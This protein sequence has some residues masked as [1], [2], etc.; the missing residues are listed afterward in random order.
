MSN[1]LATNESDS[2]IIRY[3]TFVIFCIAATS[4][5][6]IFVA[7]KPMIEDIT[8]ETPVIVNIMF[9]PTLIIGFLYGLKI[10]ERVMQPSE[11]RTPFKR[12]IVKLF[13]FFF[14]IGGLFSSV[15]FALHGGSMMPEGFVFDV[16]VI[17]S[18]GFLT[19]K[20]RTKDMI[21]SG[22]SNIYPREVEEV[23]L[24]HDAVLEASVVGRIHP[25]WGEEVV[26]FVVLKPDVKAS[27][28]DLDKF[29]LDN[30]AR[31]KRPKNY[32]FLKSLPKNNYGKILKT[33]LREQLESDSSESPA[34]N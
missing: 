3:S 30:I 18:D 29:C 23:L 4:A 6:I 5:L 8:A 13:L 32:R 22:G 16:G 17:D 34:V 14:V 15:N 24:R 19:L 28:Q 2:I 21:I 11:A 20:D 26:A 33:V 31:F 7:F 27:K 10:T 1:W 9:I 12:G 25:D